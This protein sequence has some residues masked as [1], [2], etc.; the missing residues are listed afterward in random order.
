MDSSLASFDGS[1]SIKM[2]LKLNVCTL[3]IMSCLSELDLFL[4]ILSVL[5][6]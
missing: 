4:Y 2:L 3:K 5:V 1:F 6:E